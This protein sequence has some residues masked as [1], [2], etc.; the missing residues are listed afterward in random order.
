MQ[1]EKK[2][3]PDVAVVDRAIIYDAET[4]EI[5]GSHTFGVAAQLSEEGRRRFDSLLSRQV[6]TLEERLGRKLAVHRSPE[7]TQLTSLHHRIDLATGRLTEQT[8]GIARIKVE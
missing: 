5:V 1:S 7:A 2:L 6:K 4:G 8:Q 3:S